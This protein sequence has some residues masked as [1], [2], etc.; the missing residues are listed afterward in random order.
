MKDEAYIVF[1]KKG[2]K[3]LVKNL[4]RLKSG[5]YACLLKFS[6]DES[7]FVKPP[8]PVADLK[9]E[10]GFIIQEDVPVSIDPVHLA[11]QVI[12]KLSK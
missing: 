12:G 8:L 11:D 9:I 2:I 1:N 3:K 5:E 6:V 4:P 10:Q 7:N